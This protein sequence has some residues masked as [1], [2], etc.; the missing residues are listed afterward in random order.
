MNTHLQKW[1]VTPKE[2]MEIQ[3][4]L[5]EKIVLKPL[6]Q[7]IKLIGGADVSMSLFAKNGFAGF[8]T[9][10]YPDLQMV[11]HAVVESE[12]KFPYIP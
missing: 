3:K 8:V 1:N 9:L 12:I 6:S 10:S 2:A 11:D 4:Q 7:P 5:K